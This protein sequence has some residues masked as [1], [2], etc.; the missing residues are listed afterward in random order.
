V[1]FLDP[2]F[3]DEGTGTSADDH[4]HADIRAG[5]SFLNQVYEAVTSGPAWGRTALVVNYDEWGG[6]F[7]HVAPAVVPDATPQAGTGQRGFRTPC[8]LISPRSRRHYVAHNSYDHASVL[9]MIEWRWGLPAL[10]SRDAAA[11]NIAEVLDFTNPP[12]LTAPRWDVPPAVSAP[13]G[14]D[15]TADYEDWNKLAAMAAQQGWRV[16][17]TV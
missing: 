14:P 11:R 7:D 3:Q 9:K 1:S 4:P 2:K 8:L 6:F 10:T 17:G 16:G 12:D 15:G 5:Q 13:C